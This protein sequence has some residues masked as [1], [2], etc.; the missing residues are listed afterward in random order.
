MS[1]YDEPLPL[2]LG[3]CPYCDAERGRNGGWGGS[4]EMFARFKREHD[5]GHERHFREP[6]RDGRGRIVGGHVHNKTVFGKINEGCWSFDPETIFEGSTALLV[7]PPSGVNI[8]RLSGR[9]R[10]AMEEESALAFKERAEEKGNTEF[11][12]QVDKE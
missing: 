10:R 12:V 9:I 3:E 5:T 6:L 8:S 4:P 11:S 1:Q 2:A 7:L